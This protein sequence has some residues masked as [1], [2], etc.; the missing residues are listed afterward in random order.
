MGPVGRLFAGGSDSRISG[1]AMSL[2]KG[3]PLGFHGV[4]EVPTVDFS[5]SKGSKNRLKPIATDSAGFY[6]KARI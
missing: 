5:Q 2:K 1:V 3:V 6:T 4:S